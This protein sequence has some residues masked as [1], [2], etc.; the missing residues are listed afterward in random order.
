MLV[1]RTR[2]EVRAWHA[3]KRTAFVPTMGS[4]HAGH[5]S[6]LR[7]AQSRGNPV[8]LSIFVN[9]LQFGP[10]E[11]FERY[12]R[13]LDRDLAL[14]E[15]VGVDL[16]FTP[17][18]EEMYPFGEPWI[19][20]VPEHGAE[21]LCGRSRPG[22]FRGVLTVVAKLFGIVAP[23]VAV[24]GEKDFQQLTLIR[25]M[26]AD[27]EMPIEILAGPTVREAD[28]LALSSRNRYLSADERSR[29]LALVGALRQCES[30]F[31]AG[32]TDA[33]VYRER[34]REAADHGVA[35]EYA[36]VVHPLTLD[37]LDQVEAGSVCAIAGRVGS[38]RLIDNLRLGTELPRENAA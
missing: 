2:D 16:V 22:H 8:V 35:V 13:D 29:A 24:F 32:V 14:A 9:P 28:G 21:A 37:S 36:E 11:D 18:A 26:V 12:P 38:T 15:E 17:S 1:V 33:A 31:A 30:L 6:L 23:Q 3:G 20:V 25:R 19:T 27:L 34:L 5:E 10:G 4:L 7:L